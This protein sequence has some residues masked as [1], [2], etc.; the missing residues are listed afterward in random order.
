MAWQLPLVQQRRDAVGH[1]DAV[2]V[3][4]LPFEHD[5]M[6]WTARA[7]EHGEGLSLATRIPRGHGRA[8]AEALL[9]V[10]LDGPDRRWVPGACARIERDDGEAADAHLPIDV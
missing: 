1:V 7:G 5:P 6:G 9:N 2:V 10:R 4:E 8:V 3:E